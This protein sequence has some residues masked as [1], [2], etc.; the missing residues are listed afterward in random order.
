MGCEA[1]TKVLQDAAAGDAQA[2]DQLFPLVYNEL[3]QMAQ[4]Q[5]ARERAEHTLQP[6]ALVHDVYLRLVGSD[7]TKWPDRRYF[8]AAAGQAMRRVLVEHARSRSRD[9]VLFWLY[10]GEP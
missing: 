10:S 9:K 3:R 8:F 6:T 4:A 1:V 5:M 7:T 2:V